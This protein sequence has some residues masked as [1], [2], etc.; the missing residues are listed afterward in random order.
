M[1]TIESSVDTEIDKALE[2][3]PS[4]SESDSLVELKKKMGIDS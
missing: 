3:A 2:T 4:A 1:A